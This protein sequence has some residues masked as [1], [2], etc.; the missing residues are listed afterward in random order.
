MERYLSVFQIRFSWKLECVK[1]S[2][3]FFR[4]G[5]LYLQVCTIYMIQKGYKVFLQLQFFSSLIQMI[6]IL[7]GIRVR[8]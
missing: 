2:E 7:I 1:Y 4:L 8:P 6:D 5:M 3:A